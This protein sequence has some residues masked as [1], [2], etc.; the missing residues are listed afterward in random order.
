MSSIKLRAYAKLNL[1]LDVTGRRED[2]YHLVDM[3]NRSVCLSDTVT[4]TETPDSEFSISCNFAYIP[5]DSRNL[6]WK[7]AE[8]LSA[9]AGVP[10]PRVRVE[11]EKTIPTQAGLGGGS[12]DAAAV[13][14]GLNALE[15]WGF[16]DEQLA[17][18]GLGIGAD[19]PFCLRGGA[20]RVTGIGEVM[21]PFEDACRYW[22]VVVMPRR[23]HSTAE[24]FK[25][26]DEEGRVFEHPD[27]G[28]VK[29]ALEAGEL[30]AAFGSAGNIF[31]QAIPDE[32]TQQ[33]RCRM[34]RLGALHSAMTGTGAAVFGIFTSPHSAREACASF[35]ETKHSA[36]SV[37]P[38]CRGVEI[39]GRT[40]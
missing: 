39:I 14:T 22:M 5:T 8:A 40:D 24:I 13:L 38:S 11:L 30:R 27:T 15:G 12:A 9:A 25:A 4:L 33:I 17:E 6:C 34:D 18:I 21:E 32:A 37:R 20:A 16:S 1:S 35:R 36:W 23:G 31:E 26:L 2:G 28:A 3:I 29:A 10:M 19:V 7:A